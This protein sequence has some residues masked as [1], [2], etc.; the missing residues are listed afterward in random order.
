LFLQ[1]SCSWDRSE[2]S[3]YNWGWVLFLFPFF[4]L[5]FVLFSLLFSL[6]EAAAAAAAGSP[7]ISFLLSFF[8]S[9]WNQL[10][11]QSLGLSVCV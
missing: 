3:S 2:Y 9:C 10:L 6:E 5:S 8:V 4:L 7:V 1:S 11:L